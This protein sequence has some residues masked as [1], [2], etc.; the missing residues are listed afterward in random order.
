MDPRLFDRTINRL[1]YTYRMK[2]D[3]AAA[4]AAAAILEARAADRALHWIET[5]GRDQLP[6]LADEI[7]RAHL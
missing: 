6:D 5:E 2:R 1:A 4:K 3:S 7:R